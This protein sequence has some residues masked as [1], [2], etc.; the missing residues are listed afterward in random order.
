MLRSAFLF[1]QAQL[2]LDADLDAM[3]AVR[4]ASK[5][6]EAAGTESTLARTVVRHSLPFKCCPPAT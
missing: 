2:L 5:A 6:K 4:A 1:L 3:D